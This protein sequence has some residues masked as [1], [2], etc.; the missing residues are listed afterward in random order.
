MNYNSFND[1]R[2]IELEDWAYSEVRNRFRA[3]PA[4]NPQAMDRGHDR[5]VNGFLA[6]KFPS[7]DV[8]RVSNAFFQEFTQAVSQKRT[9]S[10]DHQQKHGRGIGI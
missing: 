5:P 10:H 4:P 2:P 3:R 7:Q 9:L 1:R 8:N 6:E